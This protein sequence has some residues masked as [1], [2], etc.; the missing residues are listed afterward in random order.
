M[1]A[2][3]KN[4]LAALNLSFVFRATGDAAG[5]GAAEEPV[6]EEPAAEEPVAEEPV[7][8]EPIAEEPVAPAAT[9]RSPTLGEPFLATSASESESSGI[10]WQSCPPLFRCRRCGRRDPALPRRKYPCAIVCLVLCSY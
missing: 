1:A 9:G 3:P 5:E 10:V 2:E 6:A 7:A 4:P 8:E